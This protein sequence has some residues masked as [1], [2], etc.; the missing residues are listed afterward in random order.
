ML[1]F[2][3][4]KTVIP[5]HMLIFFASH[6][7][8]GVRCLVGGPSEF[9]FAH[10]REG[11]VLTW[12]RNTKWAKRWRK[13]ERLLTIPNINAIANENQTVFL[14]QIS[15]AFSFL[16]NI[17]LFCLV[18]VV[19]MRQ[20]N[21]RVISPRL[22]TCINNVWSILYQ[23]C[24]YCVRFR[25]ISKSVWLFKLWWGLSG[26]IS[27]LDFANCHWNLLSLTDSLRRRCVHCDE[28]LCAVSKA[29]LLG[30]FCELFLLVAHNA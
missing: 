20:K 7:F 30:P 14:F 29:T 25:M 10:A 26:L 16:R 5:A 18:S 15:F 28:Q 24:L 9:E 21:V 12:S 4:R 22:R 8:S 11:I 13:G 1:A 2:D 23:L 27:Y 17:I 19:V 6:S 3:F